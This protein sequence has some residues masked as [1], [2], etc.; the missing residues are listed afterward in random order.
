MQCVHTLRIVSIPHSSPAPVVTALTLTGVLW[1]STLDNCMFTDSHNLQFSD[2]RCAVRTYSDLHY[3]GE[4]EH[5]GDG[6]VG[7]VALPQR[8]HGQAEVRGGDVC[9][10]CWIHWIGKGD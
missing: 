10:V 8:V 6:G 2:K 9:R 1:G 3:P 4:S 5:G 7:E